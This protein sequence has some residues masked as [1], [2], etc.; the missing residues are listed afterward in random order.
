MI[1]KKFIPFLRHLVG[2]SNR[3]AGEVEAVVRRLDHLAQ[4]PLRGRPATLH[5][6]PELVRDAHGLVQLVVPVVRV[7]LEWW[8]QFSF[9]CPVGHRLLERRFRRIGS[10]V[11]ITSRLLRVSAHLCS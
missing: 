2:Q 5:V 9:H 11:R 4:R 7:D 3:E 6:V 8:A 1:M 10:F